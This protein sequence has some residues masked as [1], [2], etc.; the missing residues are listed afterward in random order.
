MGSLYYTM[1]LFHNLRNILSR[2]HKRFDIQWKQD[3]IEYNF[4]QTEGVVFQSEEGDKMSELMQKVCETSYCL[5]TF[6]TV[7]PSSDIQHWL[8][9]SHT[10]M[11]EECLEHLIQVRTAWERYSD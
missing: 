6:E 5:H 11:L 1:A 3:D 8:T 10:D 9:F 2:S 4:S 7:F